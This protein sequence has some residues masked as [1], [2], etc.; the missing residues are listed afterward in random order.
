MSIV[1][2]FNLEMSYAGYHSSILNTN[3]LF[4]LPVTGVL[5]PVGLCL[6]L[7]ILHVFACVFFT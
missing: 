3:E 2:W 1:I 6:V 5:L 4:L 7:D